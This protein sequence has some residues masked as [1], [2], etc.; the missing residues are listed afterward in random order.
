MGSWIWLITSILI[1]IASLW[2]FICAIKGKWFQ[3]I[4]KLTDTRAGVT[5]TNEVF[6]FPLL[7]SKAVI[8]SFILFIISFCFRQY[9][10]NKNLQ[11]INGQRK[12][13]IDSYVLFEASAESENAAKNVL[14]MQ[15]A[16]SIYQ[17]TLT[18]VLSGKQAEVSNNQLLELTRVF[19]TA[20]KN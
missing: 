10:I 6:D 7:I 2:V 13:A 14:L 9:S 12:N 18:G 19:Q 11:V 20:E 16:K 5:Y 15:L 17:M 3:P 8:I 1:S 4:I